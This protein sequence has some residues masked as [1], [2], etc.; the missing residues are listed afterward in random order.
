[1]GRLFWRNSVLLLRISLFFVYTP[2]NFEGTLAGFP[3]DFCLFYPGNFSHST[4]PAPAVFGLVVEIGQHRPSLAPRCALPHP[5]QNRVPRGE[6][7]PVALCC[8]GLGS[9]LGR[10]W[11]LPTGEQHP[12]Q[13]ARPSP[14]APAKNSA[15]AFAMALFFVIGRNVLATRCARRL[16]CGACRG[17]LQPGG[18]RPAPVSTPAS[19]GAGRSPL[20]SSTRAGRRDKSFCPCHKTC[21]NTGFSP[22]F[23]LHVLCENGIHSGSDCWFLYLV[24]SVSNRSHP[25]NTQ[26]APGF[27]FFGLF[28]VRFSLFRCFW[29]AKFLPALL[30]ILP[31]SGYKLK[32]SVMPCRREVSFLT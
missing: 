19:V 12:R 4:K 32:P 11:A 14:S 31:H 28:R 20:G 8:A 27:A 18:L 16:A 15:T 7:V 22:V 2:A 10:C 1:M 26:N 5:L 29:G 9:R 24:L 30:C 3:T 25:P 6:C 23:F 17:D 21:E 13:Q